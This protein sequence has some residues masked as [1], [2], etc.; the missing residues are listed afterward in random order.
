MNDKKKSLLNIFISMGTKIIILISSILVRRVL[1]ETLGNEYNGINSLFLSVIGVLSIAE[2]G[3]GSAITFCMYKPIV[4]GDEKTV[5]GLYQLFR[6]IYTIISFILLIAGIIVSF[7]I[8]FM[9]KDYSMDKWKLILY[10]YIELIACV[11]TYYYGAKSSL[12]NAYKNNYVSTFISFLGSILLYGIQCAALLIFK[13]YTAY[14]GCKIVSVFILYI[15]YSLYCSKKYK[16][17]ISNKGELTHD[18]KVEVKSNIQA[19]FLHKISAMIFSSIDNILISALFG[20]ILLGKYS[21]YYLI[22]SSMNETIKLIFIPLT[23]IIGHMMVK[24][25]KYDVKK[26]YDLL[27]NINIITGVIFYLGY[28]AIVDDLVLVLF[29]DGLQ[30]DKK[31]L[32]ILTITYF[33]QYLR[34]A[35]SN[36]KDS[37][38][39]YQKDK[40]PALCY[41]ILNVILSV[42]FAYLFGVEGVLIASLIIIIFGYHITDIYVMYKYYFKEKGL[43]DFICKMLVSLIFVG[44]IFIMQLVKVDFKNEILSIITN[45]FIS[46]GISLAFIAVYEITQIKSIK[47]IYRLYKGI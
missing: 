15:L 32:I 23:S 41:S 36:F 47:S 31:L 38:G 6:K 8:P 45:G 20:V 5:S 17:I 27:N 35:C 1:I 2:L 33:I 24:R 3:I 30:I 21:N 22:L 43:F 7:F 26:V 4:N 12:I 44:L 25:D 10:F 39:L 16:N 9:A 28:F 14:L 40:I 11:L 46:V 29:G 13:S 42:A 37:A 19:L 34:Q 18:N